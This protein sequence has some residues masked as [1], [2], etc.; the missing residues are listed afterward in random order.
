MK[1]ITLGQ[2]SLLPEPPQ[3]PWLVCAQHDDEDL[4]PRDQLGGGEPITMRHCEQ[5]GTA[6]WI[7]V[8]IVATFAV[9]HR[10]TCRNCHRA[11]GGT[12]YLHPLQIKRIED[13]GD[14][15]EE[16]YLDLKD[17]REW[18]AQKPDWRH[19]P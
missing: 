1:G 11:A 16:A 7:Y 5:C 3:G 18:L 8:W 6:V 9:T 14:S 15:L 2:H 10:V 19:Q 12:V 17:Q 13:A 4:E